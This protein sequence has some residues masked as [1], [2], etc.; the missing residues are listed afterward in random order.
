LAFMT[1]RR[2]FEILELERDATLDDAR[3]AYK[4]IVNVWHPDRF[5][6]N[7]R[8]KHKAEQKLK[9]VNVAYETV[10]AFFK[11]S[12]PSNGV[13]EEKADNIPRQTHHGNDSRGQQPAKV[14]SRT[15]IAAEVGTALILS[16][17]SYLSARLHHFVEKDLP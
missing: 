8:L 5:T 9:E 6:A 4:D 13:L 10:K 15:E 16:F 12:T 11:E 3:Q 17:C 14:R 7:P 1:I 2:S